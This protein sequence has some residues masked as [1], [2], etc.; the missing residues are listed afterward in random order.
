[1][2]IRSKSFKDWFK[3]NLHEYIKDI[4]SHGADA[5]YPKITYTADTVD[6]FD[7]FGDEIWEMAA[8]DAEDLGYKNV[9]AMIAEFGRSDML[10]DFDS[11]KNLM[12]WYGCE[13]LANQLTE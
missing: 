5:G 2:I 3:A 9:A 1:M 10:S 13:K 11:F 7:K 6:I 4:A 8:E 12:V